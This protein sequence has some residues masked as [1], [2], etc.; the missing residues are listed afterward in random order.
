V[1]RQSIDPIKTMRNIGYA[2]VRI[3]SKPLLSSP[4]ASP[5]F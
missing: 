2:L 1:V 4:I 5:L 3:N